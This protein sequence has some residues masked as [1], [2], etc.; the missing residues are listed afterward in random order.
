VPFDTF[1]T[2]VVTNVGVLGIEQGFAPLI[3]TGRAAA[4]I[5]VGKIRDKVIAVAGEPRVR[6]VLTLG[7]TFDHR[8]VDGHHLGRINERLQAI[9]EAPAEHLDRLP[10]DK[11]DGDGQRRAP[12]LG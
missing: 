8:I 4:L 3:P 10:D 1:G 9:L 12:V 6:P 7:A 11:S 5:T 2:V